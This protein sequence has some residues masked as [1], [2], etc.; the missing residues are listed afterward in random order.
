MFYLLK[1]HDFL[2]RIFS[3]ILLLCDEIHNFKIIP[4]LS[5]VNKLLKILI[6]IFDF[7]KYLFYEK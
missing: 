2:F 5:E 1:V 7:L 6:N 4:A 3:P